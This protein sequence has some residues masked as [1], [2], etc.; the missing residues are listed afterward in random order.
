MASYKGL[1][2][3]AA[4]FQFKV[5]ADETEIAIWT[6]YSPFARISSEETPVF[7]YLS[8]FFDGAQSGIA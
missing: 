1:M 5:E 6:I 4:E 3:T 7:L 8:L 2:Q